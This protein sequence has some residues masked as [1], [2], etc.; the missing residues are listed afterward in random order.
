MN[1]NQV[2]GGG[3]LT[4][5]EIGGTAG[6]LFNLQMLEELPNNQIVINQGSVEVFDIVNPTISSCPLNIN[7]SV[8]PPCYVRSRKLDSPDSRR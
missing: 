8:A 2:G 6:F 7:V 1:F 3:S 4:T 5:V